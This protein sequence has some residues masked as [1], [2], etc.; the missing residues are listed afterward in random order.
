LDRAELGI[1][2][3]LGPRNTALIEVGALG[4]LLLCEPAALS[5]SAH[6][7]GSGGHEHLP[8]YVVKNIL[9]PNRI[10]ARLP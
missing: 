10:K 9:H 6:E 7:C 5:G 2:A 1:A 3:T 4:E 8:D